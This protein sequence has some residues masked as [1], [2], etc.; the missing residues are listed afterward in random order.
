MIALVDCNNFFVS[1]ERLFR[2][3]LTKV[4]VAVLSNNDGC[5]VARSNEVKAL[6]VPMGVPHFQVRDV[7]KKNNVTL[8]S[9]NFGLYSNISQ[10][11]ID[12][13]R[14]FS[15]RIEVY[16]IDEA[17]LSL[18]YLAIADYDAWAQNI[19]N[20]IAKNV[21]MPVSVGVAPT[22]TLAKLA[23]EYAKKHSETCVINPDVQPESYQKI[24]QYTAVADIWGIGRQ[25][26]KKLVSAGVRDAWALTRVSN[27]WLH[28][29]M[30]VNGE[31]LQKELKG[32]VVYRLEDLKKPQKSVIASR[33]FGH[34]VSNQYELDVSVASF[35]TQA[36]ARLRKF[37]QVA[38][39][40]GVYLRYRDAE[41]VTKSQS[42]V[43]ELA[44]HSN[45]TSELV[46]T[47]L[48]L[49]NSLYLPE[50]DYKKSGVFAYHLSSADRVQQSLIDTKTPFQR[51]RKQK[52]MKAIDEI[53]AR[54]GASTVH[55]GTI[56][57]RQTQWQG[58]RELV[59]PSYTTSWS[60]LPKVYA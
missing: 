37:N 32:E 24:L 20:T 40:F 51:A 31:R 41:G 30:G 34:T 9:S 17:F 59:S 14:Q 46:Q 27:H 21:G 19:R 6:G 50:V 5:V 57:A 25:F 23:S 4:P 7:F 15:P 60:Q 49:L 52:L 42:A 39:L 45:D 28:Q 22:K 56:D 55:V 13:L 16:S 48:T 8:F 43:M 47:A 10:R 54:F 33:S 58:K 36:A 1:C 26:S 44:P 29:Q 12:Q 35:A 3:D 53:N 2:P 38:G 11:I 18:D